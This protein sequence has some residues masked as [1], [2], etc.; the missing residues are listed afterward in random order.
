MTVKKYLTIPNLLSFFRILLVPAFIV[1]Y[2]RTPES[3]FVAVW[4]IIILVLSGVT[5]LF[6]GMIARKFNQVSDL[7]KMLD[8]VA[9]KLTQIAV[10]ACLTIRFR[11]LWILLAV[12]IVKEL[13]MVA[14]GLI[15]LKKKKQVPS[16]K[17]FGK[18]AT[19]EFYCA[20]ALFLVFPNFLE[21]HPALI[22]VLMWITLVLLLFSLFMYAI[23][24]FG[25]SNNKGDNS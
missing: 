4:P 3:G 9:D 18:T 24:Y 5:D 14:G 16:A 12:Y 19:F 7:G 11:Q 20:M 15:V 2:L 1:A 25:I 22:A 21:Q 10:V 23:Q 6:D 8:P 13:A 17:W